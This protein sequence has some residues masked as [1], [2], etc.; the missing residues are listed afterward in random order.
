M[1]TYPLLQKR[2]YN[3]LQKRSH[4]RLRRKIYYRLQNTR[5]LKTLHKRLSI[6]Y[7]LKRLQKRL[8]KRLSISIPKTYTPHKYLLPQQPEIFEISRSLTLHGFLSC[9][10]LT[11]PVSLCVRPRQVCY[12]VL[13]GFLS[14]VLRTAQ[15]CPRCL[16]RLATGL[17]IVSIPA[18]IKRCSHR[19]TIIKLLSLK[20]KSVYIDRDQI[21]PCWLSNASAREDSEY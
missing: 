8:H 15:S 17:C 12:T 6:K 7:L 19:I 20:E 5:L 2:I 10:Y 18:P 21:L 3:G 1:E 4:K 16:R 9:P 11:S 13:R 14:H